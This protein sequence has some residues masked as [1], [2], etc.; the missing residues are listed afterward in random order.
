VNTAARAS[1]RMTVRQRIGASL[2]PGPAVPLLGPRHDHTQEE[3]RSHP[4]RYT[5]Q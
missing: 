4:N 1:S 5:R 3:R 2:V